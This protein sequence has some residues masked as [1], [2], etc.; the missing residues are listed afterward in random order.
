MPGIISGGPAERW[1]AGATLAKGIAGTN[2]TFYRHW[3]IGLSTHSLYE[4]EED[5]RLGV[6]NGKDSKIEK[7]GYNT[8]P[9]EYH[10]P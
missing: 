9:A 10:H 7:A 1:R 2:P 5:L 4:D 8:G 6:A 3:D